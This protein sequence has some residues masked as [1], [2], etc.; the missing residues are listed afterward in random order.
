MSNP[1]LTP[2]EID[3]LAPADLPSYRID[4]YQAEDE[5]TSLSD[6]AAG[7]A[8]QLRS[9]YAT[10]LAL[11]E[12]LKPVYGDPLLCL[13]AILRYLKEEDWSAFVGPLRQ[14]GKETLARPGTDRLRRVLHDL[15]GGAFQSLSLRLQLM[16]IAEPR[17]E[18]AQQAFFLVRDHLKIMRNC[19]ADLDLERYAADSSRQDHAIGLLA[20]KWTKA[21]FCGED[22]RATVDVLC[23]YAGVI[24]ESCLEF[25]TLDRIIYNLMNNAARFTADGRVLLAMVPTPSVENPENV[26]FVIANRIAPEHA[27]TLRDRFGDRVDELLR[28][29]F[30]TG[31]NGLGLRICAD[32]CAQAYGL[33]DFDTARD[34]GYFGARLQ[35]DLFL[36]WFHWPTAGD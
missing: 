7:D 16:E 11:F 27:S 26:R 30:T 28:G 8:A 24:C 21:P 9:L 1:L 22:H 25:S 35:D 19:V 13:E 14:L 29:G 31:G 10:L 3:G 5:R 34:G 2:A 15:R 18:D 6:F 12:R 32:F 17:P 33:A 20:E 23:R 4:R 36:V